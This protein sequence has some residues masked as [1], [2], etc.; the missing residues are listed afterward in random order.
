[1]LVCMIRVEIHEMPAQ[2]TH[3]SRQ[4]NCRNRSK[5]AGSVNLSPQHLGSR[6][7]WRITNDQ[8][9]LQNTSL[10]LRKERP[11]DPVIYVKMGKMGW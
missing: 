11:R 9:T 2:D 5:N 3:M 4:R 6:K 1:M 7:R 8:S 10:L